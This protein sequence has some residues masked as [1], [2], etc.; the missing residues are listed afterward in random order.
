VP[1]GRALDSGLRQGKHDARG[2]AAA[3]GAHPVRR[4]ADRRP[5]GRL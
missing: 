2:A 4:R 3:G 5:T 1:L